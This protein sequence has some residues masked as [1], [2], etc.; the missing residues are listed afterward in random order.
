MKE[1][2]RILLQ[3]S[4]KDAWHRGEYKRAPNHVERGGEGPPV[5]VFRTADPAV[6]PWWMERLIAELEGSW[7]SP[8]WHRLVLIGDFILWLLAIHPFLDGNG[9]LA[10]ALTTLLLLKAGYEYAP[11]ASLERVIE[12]RKVS[13]YIALRAAQASAPS[14]AG[15]YGDWLDFLL[16]ALE[17]QQQVL[18]G[19]LQRAAEREPLPAAQTAIMDLITQRGPMT[20]PEI[21]AAMSVPARTVRY[22]LAQLTTQ[23]LLDATA[24]K[25]GRR[26]SLPL[27]SEPVP[28]ELAAAGAAVVSGSASFASNEAPVLTPLDFAPI[29]QNQVMSS[30]NGRA[31]ATVVVVGS[32]TRSPL[33]DRE[34]DAFEIFASA[35]ASIAEP[36]RATP[37]VGWWRIPDPPR[38]DKFQMWLYPGPLVQVHWALDAS[39]AP[40]DGNIALDPI[41]LV[42][43]WRHVL[44]HAKSA[45]SRAGFWSVCGWA[46]HPN[47]SIEPPVHRGYG[48]RQVAAADPFWSGGERAA[49]DGVAHSCGPGWYC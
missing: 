31:Y 19:R 4:E 14:D 32:S 7:D 25:A 39:D 29:L 46:E 10:R 43:Y 9:R 30:P 44:R 11:Y 1:F 33:G 35:V 47:P 13:Y 37:E 16:S 22:H 48:L 18:E 2:H 49:L 42:V 36:V 20:T 28:S 12:D 41:G 24:R 17:A 6:T 8:E 26:Y 3:Y 27:S 45:R 23:K 5:V 15:S 38:M 34:L 40:D 21:A